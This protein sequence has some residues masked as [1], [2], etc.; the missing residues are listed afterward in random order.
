[1]AGIIPRH[2]SPISHDQLAA[3]ARALAT[4]AWDEGL[5]SFQAA[6]AVAETPEALEGVATAAWWLDDIPLIFESRERAYRLYQ[7]AGDRRGAARLATWLGLDHYLFRGEMARANGWLQRAHRLLN[8]VAPSFEHG[9]LAL[10]EAHIALFERN[11]V[12]T[13]KSLSAT[14][15]TLAQSLELIDLEM[16]ALA[17]EGLALVSEGQVSEGMRQLDEAS[18]AA[19]AGEMTD[20]DSIVTACCYLIYACERVRDYDRAIQWCDRVAELCRRWSYRSMLGICRVHYAAVLTLQGDWTRADA[21]LAAAMGTLSATRPVWAGEGTLRLAELRRRQGRLDEASRLFARVSPHPVALLGQAEL[22]LANGDPVAADQLVDRFLRRVPIQD[23]TE[24]ARGLEVA[25]RVKVA[26]GALDHARAHLAELESAVALVATEPLW[27]SV[28]FARGSVA[29]AAGDLEAARRA[30]E[31]AV[32]LFLHCGAPYEVILTRLELV[33][34]L[35]A[36]GQPVAAAAAA[37]SA[38]DSA[39][40]LGA[41]LLAARASRLLRDLELPSS[42]GNAEALAGLTRREGEVLCLV[43]RG[44]SNQQIAEHLFISRRTVERHI[45]AIY[46]KIGAEGTAA[47]A[48]ATAYAIESGLLGATRVEPSLRST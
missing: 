32:D 18:T 17:L 38:L 33:P 45:S 42:A 35:S 46:A 12:A 3:G 30:F 41:G 11:D 44:Q 25:I 31:D 37:K 14:A 13:T 28:S 10:V 8:N 21:E 20:P 47:R 39:R 22:A 4:G 26:L 16:L 48:I 5:A 2:P 19:L 7:Q 27:A 34:V 43:A 9:W 40:D 1:M 36:T 15:T 6:L 23:R 29:A 24:R